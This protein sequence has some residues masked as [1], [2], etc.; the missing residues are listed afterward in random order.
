V[1]TSEE[2][3]Y[4]AASPSE[5]EPVKI[6]AYDGDILNDSGT[7]IFEN[8]FFSPISSMV[9]YEED[10]YF[11]TSGAFASDG[12]IYKISDINS[13][14]PTAELYLRLPWLPTN[15]IINEDTIYVSKLYFF[16]GGIFTYDMQ[17]PAAQLESFI[18]TDANSLTDFEIV[19][20]HL[21]ITNGSDGSVL[22]LDLSEENPS[23]TRLLTGL[24]FPTGIAVDGDLLYLS[25]ENSNSNLTSRVNIYDFVNKN[26][27]DSPI[28]EV[29]NNTNLSI[30]E[31]ARL[32]NQTYVLE[33][34]NGNNGIG[35]LLRVA[36]Q[37]SNTTSTF[38][39]KKIDVFPNPTNS[40]VNFPTTN[41]KRVDVI[42]VKGQIVLS[43]TNGTDQL[44]LSGLPK[45][46]YTLLFFLE[47]DTFGNVRIIKQ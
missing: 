26:M 22:S 37:M 24:D 27:L 25:V 13:D 17:N 44:E 14:A 12:L 32:N 20:D 43:S 46:L 35:Y 36:N 29:A 16:G 42:N 34:A 19:G 28:S 6:Y 23:F 7:V 5:F 30:V 2:K 4:V 38:E 39:N 8:P 18:D 11:V 1:V 9:I 21:L 31:L 15:L 40:I 41:P 47:D 33:F 10:L 3:I 45:G